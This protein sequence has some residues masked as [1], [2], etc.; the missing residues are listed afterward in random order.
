MVSKI[1]LLLLSATIVSGC[2]IV[3][4]SGNTTGEPIVSPTHISNQSQS[5]SSL[6]LEDTEH[7]WEEE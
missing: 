6:S 7:W 5:D 1:L 2:C 3:P 4:S